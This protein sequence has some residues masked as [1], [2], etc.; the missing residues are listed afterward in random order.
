MFYSVYLVYNNYQ[1]LKALA[2][3]FEDIWANEPEERVFSATVM[4]HLKVLRQQKAETQLAIKPAVALAKKSAS[5]NAV[6]TTTATTATEY[7]SP[8]AKLELLCAG[9]ATDDTLR[10]DTV[11]ITPQVVTSKGIGFDSA[12][13]M[14]TTD[15]VSECRPPRLDVA[16]KV[17]GVLADSVSG[18]NTGSEQLWGY[19]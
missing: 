5:E 10:D 7:I 13:A 17:G 9:E 6:S 2:G 19:W 11:E 15:S 1:E 18:Y 4:S 3:L 12:I 8:R 14:S 16:A